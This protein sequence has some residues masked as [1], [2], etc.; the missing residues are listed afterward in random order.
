MEPKTKIRIMEIV[1]AVCIC[2][3][4]AA[5][6]S[7]NLKESPDN[8]AGPGKILTQTFHNKHFRNYHVRKDVDEQ[9]MESILAIRGVLPG[10]KYGGGTF[11]HK[12]DLKLTIYKGYAFGWDEIQ[13]SVLSILNKAFGYDDIGDR[14]DY[15]NLDAGAKEAIEAPSIADAPSIIHEFLIPYVSPAPEYSDPWIKKGL[16]QC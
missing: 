13:P 11:Y 7:L 2:V 15:G 12:Y 8:N 1:T 9:S 5:I 14:E 6:L 16:I 10:D 3:I 4:V